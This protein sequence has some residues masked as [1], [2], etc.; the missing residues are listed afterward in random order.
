MLIALA[1]LVFNML[2]LAGALA[3]APRS[4]RHVALARHR[5]FWL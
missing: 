3:L 2:V 4:V 1:V 5:D